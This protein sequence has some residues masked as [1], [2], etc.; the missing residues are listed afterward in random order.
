MHVKECIEREHTKN[1]TWIRA[2]TA[3]AEAHHVLA[4]S[5]MV[6]NLLRYFSSCGVDMVELC[7]HGR[8]Q[9]MSV[10]I[11]SVVLSATTPYL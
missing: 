3:S 2:S 6:E 11:L 7:N 1:P 9:T 8:Y 5:A 4:S 10:R